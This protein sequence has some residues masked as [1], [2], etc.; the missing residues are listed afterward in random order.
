MHPI[1]STPSPWTVPPWTTCRFSTRTSF[2]I[3]VN[4]E[5]QN[6]KG[7]VFARDLSGDIHDAVPATQRNTELAGSI[8][9]QIG[10]NHLISI[11]GVYTDLTIRNQAV[12]GL[13]LRQA[14]TNFEDREDILY[15]NYSGSPTK[16]PLNPIR[17]SAPRAII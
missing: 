10:Q 17:L 5:E 4:R 6:P 11:R 13:T 9:H 16:N 7:I 8:N 15:F 2:L 1:I 3:C 14:G 12:G